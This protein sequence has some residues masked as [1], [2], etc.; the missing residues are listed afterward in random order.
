MSAALASMHP[1]RA[2]RQVHAAA[3]AGEGPVQ[4]AGAGIAST[5]AGRLT[6]SA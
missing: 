6:I 5:A 2:H 3:I 1:S 4:R